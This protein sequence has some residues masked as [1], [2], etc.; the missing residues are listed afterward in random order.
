MAPLGN[1]LRFPPPFLSFVVLGLNKSSNPLCVRPVPAHTMAPGLH[2]SY[3][4]NSGWQTEITSRS[5]MCPESRVGSQTFSLPTISRR[6]EPPPKLSEAPTFCR[7]CFFVCL[8]HGMSNSQVS[9]LALVKL[10]LGEGGSWLAGS[11]P[12]HDC[13]MS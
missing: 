11:L 2:D 8:F 3:R 9:D 13:L 4:L 7:K 10:T 5:S 6:A 12:S 1:D